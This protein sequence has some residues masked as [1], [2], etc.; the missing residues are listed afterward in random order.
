MVIASIVNMGTCTWWRLYQS[1]LS[2]GKKISLWSQDFAR[3]FAL[4]VSIGF[5]SH[6]LS[7]LFFPS[8]SFK[9]FNMWFCA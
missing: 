1:H 7:V 2:H 4:F 5:W 3:I 6:F 8:L 9:K